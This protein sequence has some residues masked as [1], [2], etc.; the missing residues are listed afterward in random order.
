MKNDR[1]LFALF[2]LSLCVISFTYGTY[3]GYKNLAPTGLI[4]KPLFLF[5]EITRW[6]KIRSIEDAVK[7]QNAEH[8]KNAANRRSNTLAIPPFKNDLYA[9][10][11]GLDVF[12][13]DL[14]GSIVHKWSIAGLNL[15]KNS[16]NITRQKGGGHIHGL[17]IFSSGD[18]ILNISFVGFPY[19]A[20]LV[21]IDK[22][23]NVLWVSDENTH[24]DV[25]IDKDG[26]IYAPYHKVQLAGDSPCPAI[27]F[28]RDGL[29]HDGVIVLS[30]N[31]DVLEKIP[32]LKSLC[33][34]P[35]KALLSPSGHDMAYFEDSRLINT[36]S[37]SEY[38][39][40]DPLHLN[41]VRPISALQAEKFPVAEAGDLLVSFRNLN[42]VAV[43][44]RKT[45][46]ITWALT[47]MFIRQHDAEI[48]NEGLLGVFDNRGASYDSA[49]ESQ[50][51]LINPLTQKIIKVYR[52]NLP[53]RL[54]VL[55]SGDVDFLQN[56]NALVVDTSGGRIFELSD[57]GN[58]LWSVNL[59]ETDINNVVHVRC[60][61]LAFLHEACSAK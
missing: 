49:V 14:E 10:T 43:Y 37:E 33:E 5:G 3:S 32:L 17:H 30:P 60:H 56:G 34:S 1:L 53:E 61:E 46:A 11:S 35:Y 44:S 28:K 57:K 8:F 40:S 20:G 31:G 48:N 52:P 51:L 7:E 36:I 9:Y 18:V 16:S 23:S 4:L 2:V 50:A 58:I 24:H 41:S 54:S 13:I 27:N 39:P 38:E 15:W 55:Q 26:L 47:G 22:D 45:K 19:G 21:K 6:N 12:L 42:T 25:S 29:Y 59:P